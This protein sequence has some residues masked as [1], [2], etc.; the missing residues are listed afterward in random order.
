MSTPTLQQERLVPAQAQRPEHRAS[1]RATGNPE[2][3]GEPLAGNAGHQQD[4]FRFVNF[5][6][7]MAF[8]N[9]L[10]PDCPSAGPPPRSG[11]GL[12][13]RFWV[14]LNTHDVGG[15]S[16]TDIDCARR[17]RS[18]AESGPDPYGKQGRRPGAQATGDTQTGLVVA[19]YGRHCVVET[20]DGERRIC[21]PR[22]KKKPGRGGRPVLQWLAPPA[23]AMRA[24]SKNC[25]APQRLLPPG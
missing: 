21:H 7:T 25:G 19:S 11:G 24:R 13:N 8:V 22:G 18:T 12:N 10:A 16:E 6:E 9:A 20:P 17:I 1:A 14:S 4:N 23:R 5:Y 2:G 15:I 3:A